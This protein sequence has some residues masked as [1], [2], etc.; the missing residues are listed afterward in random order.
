[1]HVHVSWD[2]VWLNLPFP[3]LFPWITVGHP[4]HPNLT[5]WIKCICVNRACPCNIT[6]IQHTR[7]KLKLCNFKLQHHSDSNEKFKQVRVSMYRYVNHSE[8]FLKRELSRAH[9]PCERC[10]LR[11]SCIDL[12]ELHLEI[13]QVCKYI[14]DL[15]WHNALDLCAW[16]D[17]T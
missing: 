4:W 1:M 3:S 14:D 5:L 6:T 13:A 11:V 9:T 12:H 8:T 17:S 16:A 10:I 7:N 15:Y 2:V